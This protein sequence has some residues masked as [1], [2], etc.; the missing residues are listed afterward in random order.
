MSTV[1]KGTRP[2]TNMEDTAPPPQSTR[3]HHHEDEDEDA[4]LEDIKP[5]KHDVTKELFFKVRSL[6]RQ[7]NLAYVHFRSLENLCHSTPLIILSLA[8]GIMAFLVSMGNG[9][10]SGEVEALFSEKQRKYMA[11]A[12]GIISFVQIA[13]QKL[14]ESWKF[15]AR[16]DMHLE[17]ANG[18]DRLLDKIEFDEKLMKARKI[19]S[20]GGKMH[21]DV[22][23]WQDVYEQCLLSCSSPLPLRI[24][25]AFRILETEFRLYLDSKRVNEKEGTIFTLYY[26]HVF[27]ALYHELASSY[28]FPY[29]I[30]SPKHAVANV[31]ED[32]EYYY[33]NFGSEPAMAEV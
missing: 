15:K 24:R 10:E 30:K 16:S 8:S 21:P 31:L 32:F 28:L 18:L 2:N 14:G 27:N 3:P 1:N 33:G 23:K 9:N 4:A 5:E 7:H 12:V 17:A 19:A 6:H 29:V 20:I 25:Q 26:S 13:V 22:V 11:I